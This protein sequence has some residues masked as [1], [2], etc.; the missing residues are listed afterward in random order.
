ME[1]KNYNEFEELRTLA[2]QVKMPQAARDAVLDQVQRSAQAPEA[3]TSRRQ[4][5][6]VTRRTALK[7]A[8]GGLGLAAAGLFAFSVAGRQ[9]TQDADLVVGNDAGDGSGNGSDT[10][11]GAGA[12]NSFVLT[13]FAEG[14]PQ[15]DDANIVLSGSIVSHT[16][17]W[18]SGGGWWHVRNALDLSVEG[19][20]VREVTFAL[21][22]D[23]L[24]G[25]PEE[26][27][28][29]VLFESFRQ[30]RDDIKVGDVL[31]TGGSSVTIS[32]EQKDE[33]WERDISCDFQEDE[34]CD[35]LMRNLRYGEDG[36]LAEVAA[37]VNLRFAQL[38]SVPTLAVS[39]T[40]DNEETYTERYRI[41]PI[42]DFRS[43]YAEWYAQS[44]GGLDQ[45]VTP[46]LYTI[47]RLTDAE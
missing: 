1:Y 27:K 45:S 2:Q 11:G 18:Y 35:R 44:D 4:R 39:A 29:G 17:G 40:F 42:D 22:G 38:I 23:G 10:S 47:E 46:A 14:I 19:G 12:Q 6:G 26:P 9:A 15:A 41:A 33:T 7:V 8:A 34:E 37:Y 31:Q 21:E 3:A 5:R 32:C 43:K 30:V 24:A 13:A 28:E 20:N 25:T 16:S 36:A